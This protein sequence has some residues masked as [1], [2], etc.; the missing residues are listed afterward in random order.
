MA[1]YPDGI[2][3]GNYCKTRTVTVTQTVYPTSTMGGLGGPGWGA[4]PGWAV[5]SAPPPESTSDS[6]DSNLSGASSSDVPGT[7]LAQYPS[8]T[9]TTSQAATTATIAL[10]T[11]TAPSN[12]TSTTHPGTSSTSASQI[13]GPVLGGIAGAGLLAFLLYW[14]CRRKTRLRFSF[15]RKS[16]EEKE[17]VRRLTE[18]EEI[19]AEREKALRDLENRRNQRRMGSEVL[20]GVDFG[21]GLGVDGGRANGVE[22]VERGGASPRSPRWI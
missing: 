13:A 16:K 18:A 21:T 5:A 3:T 14:C 4:G 1:P 8:S 15:K 10:T 22:V 6:S 11:T 17:N 2:D 12:N 20:R 19:A 7:A 9:A